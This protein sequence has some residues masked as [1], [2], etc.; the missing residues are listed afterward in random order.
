MSTRNRR[1]LQFDCSL[2]VPK[3]F[4][5]VGPL[6]YVSFN[7]DILIGGKLLYT[8]MVYQQNS[9]TLNC[10]LNCSL[11]FNKGLYRFVL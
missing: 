3:N 6:L 5:F 4:P 11:L 7:V 8:L 2:D 1:T 10:L 9:L